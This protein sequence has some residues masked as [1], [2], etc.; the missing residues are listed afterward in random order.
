MF[1]DLLMKYQA[2]QLIFNRP[3]KTTQLDNPDPWLR[4]FGVFGLRNQYWAL[5]LPLRHATATETTMLQAALPAFTP[6]VPE[7][8]LSPPADPA[9]ITVSHNTVGGP[10]GLSLKALLEAGPQVLGERGIRFVTLVNADLA[11][12]DIVDQLTPAHLLDAEFQSSTLQ[13]VSGS[14]LPTLWDEVW[15]ATPGTGG[16]PPV[17]GQNLWDALSAP[18]TDV[19]PSGNGAEGGRFD[20]WFGFRR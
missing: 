15:N 9:V 14:T 8:F 7:F 5:R 17:F 11:T 13:V 19:L 6:G 12:R 16:V 1:S 3:M 20:S 4:L 10:A 18:S 2:I